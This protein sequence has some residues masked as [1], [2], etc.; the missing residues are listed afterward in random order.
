MYR[1]LVNH[2]PDRPDTLVQ[3]LFPAVLAVLPLA[4]VWAVLLL[5]WAPVALA[6]FGVAVLLRARLPHW[7]WGQFKEAVH[8][9]PVK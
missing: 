6:V 5:W 2:H 4:G 9:P 8:R 7:L 3:G 1:F